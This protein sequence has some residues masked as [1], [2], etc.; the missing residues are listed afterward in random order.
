MVYC[1]VLHLKLRDPRCSTRYLAR[2]NRRKCKYK[3][4]WINIRNKLRLYAGKTINN[5]VSCF[6][7]TCHQYIIFARRIPIGLNGNFLGSSLKWLLIINKLHPRLKNN[8]S[9]QDLNVNHDLEK[10]S[11]TLTW[12]SLKPLRLEKWK[13]Y[14]HWYNLLGCVYIHRTAQLMLHDHDHRVANSRDEKKVQ[15]T[16]ETKK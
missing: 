1:H 16:Y 10:F 13:R 9:N 6:L 15:L 11:I 7:I 12:Q 3:L 2:R 4:G 5:T 14:I 8:R